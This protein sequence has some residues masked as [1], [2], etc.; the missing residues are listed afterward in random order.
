MAEK[1]KWMKPKLLV[2][3]RVEAKEAVLAA[4]KWFAENWP[5]CPP[6]RTGPC[7]GGGGSV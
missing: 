7:V 4:C 3:V 5:N 6:G 2:L 1:K